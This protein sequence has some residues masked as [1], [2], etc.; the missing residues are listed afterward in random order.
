MHIQPADAKLLLGFSAERCETQKV[1]GQ[2][3]ANLIK[4]VSALQAY[5]SREMT[6]LPFTVYTII[7]SIVPDMPPK[8]S[9][10]TKGKQKPQEETREES[11]QAV[12]ST[13]TRNLF[14][15]LTLLI[16]YI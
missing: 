16:L 5:L 3:G 2:K 8:K 12:V 11:L 13:S 14:P 7:Q 4:P 10:H 9:K 1:K 6:H 15:R